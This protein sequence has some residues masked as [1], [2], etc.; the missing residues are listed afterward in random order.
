MYRSVE[1]RADDASAGRSRKKP[2]RCLLHSRIVFGVDSTPAGSPD[3]HRVEVSRRRML[4]AVG[5]AGLVTVL[6]A[7][8]D[9]TMPGR[10]AE[11]ETTST[12]DPVPDPGNAALPT[13]RPPTPT[14]VPGAMLCRDAWGALPARPGGRTH[15][16]TRL[17]LHH[18]GVAFTDNRAIVGRLQ[19]HQRYHQDQHGWIDIAYHVGVD[20]SGNIFELRT[21]ELVGDTATDYDPTGHFLV[22]CEG[23]FDEQ[24]V[25][26]DQ[27]H[28]AAM[29]FAWAA[30]H[31]NIPADTL[32]G[33][34]DFTADTAC[35]GADLYARVTSGELKRRVAD[36]LAAGR[37]D[38][39]RI[40][41]TDA[42]AVVAAIE[43]GR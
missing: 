18:S 13:D 39:R 41:G 6:S 42:A 27:L 33:H 8:S 20:R 15:T 12:R 4:Q 32:A 22:L 25:P 36:L 17:T 2:D 3:P 19:Q 24:S 31:F 7:C 26:E 29:A 1:C 21:P 14:V 35:P 43:A 16:L 34:R 23:N 11:P 5:G 40:C 30:Q 38:L 37:V 10:L 28:G 9:R